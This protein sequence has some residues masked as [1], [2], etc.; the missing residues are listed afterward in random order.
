MLSVENENVPLLSFDEIMQI[1]EKQIFMN[2]YLD[3]TENTVVVTDVFFSYRCVSKR[4]SDQYYLLPVWDFVGYDTIFDTG[5][6]I[7]D[8]L[9]RGSGKIYKD[10]L[11]T[12][13]AIDGSILN[14][15]LGY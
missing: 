6:G 12:V 13:N 1:F 3:G 14:E 10:S 9:Y 7:A 4:D 11:L 5:K 2:I 8:T 15:F